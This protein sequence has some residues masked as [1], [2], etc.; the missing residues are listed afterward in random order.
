MG[1]S[2]PDT[3]RRAPDPACPILHPAARRKLLDTASVSANRRRHRAAG[4]AP[5]L[6]GR[7]AWGGDKRAT[8]GGGV[9][10][11]DGR[12]RQILELEQSAARMPGKRAVCG[13]AVTQ[14][15]VI[16]RISVGLQPRRDE[17]MGPSRKS[18]FLDDR[19]GVSGPLPAARKKGCGGQAGARSGDV[20]RVP[21]TGSKMRKEGR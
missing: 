2:W 21:P 18:W 11:T 13:P 7:T 10:E 5:D 16:G 9:S 1:R 17:T 12:R 6:I 19:R 4:V 8:R 3:G 20:G 14:D 15:R